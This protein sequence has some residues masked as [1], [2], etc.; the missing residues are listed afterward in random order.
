MASFRSGVGFLRLSHP[1]LVY[2]FF[3]SIPTRNEVFSRKNFP[4]VSVLFGEFLNQFS[5]LNTISHCRRTRLSLVTRQPSTPNMISHCI[6]TRLLLATRQPLL[7]N[8][9][10]DI[11]LKINT[12]IASAEH[13]LCWSRDEHFWLSSRGQQRL[14]HRQPLLLNS[15]YDITLKINMFIASAEHILCWSGDEHFW[16]WR[17]THSALETNTLKRTF[18]LQPHTHSQL[19]ST[20]K[21]NLCRDDRQSQLLTPKHRRYCTA[22][23]QNVSRCTMAS[24]EAL[25]WSSTSSK[26]RNYSPTVCQQTRRTLYM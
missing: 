25:R 16:R 5:P 17:R 7:L 20:S 2:T 4:L 18:E 1:R 19:P 12:F 10:Y 3:S 14:S 9:E 13:I 6:Q 15:K 21:Q 26:Q 23:I 24:P 8:S 11:T 22:E